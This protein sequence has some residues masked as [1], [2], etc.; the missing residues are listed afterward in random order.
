V[1]LSGRPAQPWWRSAVTYEIYVRSFAD[2]NGDGV[3]DL[4][5]IRARLSYVRDLGADA[6]WLTP[7][8]RSPMAD[9][10][11]DVADHR[12]VDP[13]FGDLRDFDAVMAEAQSLGLRVL[14]DLVPNHTSDQHPWFRAA[15]A[16]APD[17]PERGRYI[18]RNGRGLDGA[19]PPNDWQSVFGGPAWSRTPDG[20]WYLHLFAPEQPDLNWRDPEVVAEFESILRF[21]LDRGVSGFRVDVAHGLFKDPAFPDA[22]PGQVVR[23]LVDRKPGPQW[24]QD[25]VHG[26]YR[27]WR[28]IVDSYDGD[29]ILVGEAWVHPPDRLARYVR[30]DELHQAFNFEFLQAPWDTAVLRQAIE[31]SLAATRGVGAASTWVLSS[32]DVERPVSRYGG[33]M[34]G[35]R[36]ARAALLLMLALPGS[37]YVYQGEELGLPTADLP[38][39]ALRDPIWERSGHTERGRDGSRVPLPWGGDAPPFQFGLNGSAAGSGSWLPMPPS[40]RGLT[41]ETQRDDP[42][43]MLTLYRRALRL[44]R[45][46]W[47]VAGESLRWYQPAPHT[48]VF[49]R[50]PDL[51]CAVNLGAAAARL[52]SHRQVLLASGPV[53]DDG[54]ALVVPSDTAVWL[55]T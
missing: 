27:S 30:P 8:Y 3:G 34:L 16:A 47:A 18:F 43:S 24:D 52:P 5:G 19:E 51:V 17:S 49:A 37:A 25:D 32:H 44:R 14:V 2:A 11:Y 36:R 46:A 45:Q 9:H 38:D 13:L 28:K 20:Q 54:S 23:R 31:N 22:G 39:E 15:L 40:W 33:G 50:E 41:V 53:H 29:R 26:L 10:G 21:W 6:V 12:A 55:R 7:F 42:H 48:L 1:G 35:H 4:A